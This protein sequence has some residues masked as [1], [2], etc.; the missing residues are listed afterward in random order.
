MAPSIWRRLLMQALDCAVLRALMKLGM[1]IAANRPMMATTIMISTNVKPDL[2]DVL[3]FITLPFVCCGV[4]RAPGGLFII[5]FLFTD[6]PVPTAAKILSEW[7][8]GINP[9]LT[10][11]L[12]PFHYGQDGLSQTK[13][14]CMVLGQGFGGIWLSS[15]RFV[16]KSSPKKR[17]QTAKYAEY[18]EKW[19]TSAYFA[20]SAVLSPFYFGDVFESSTFCANLSGVAVLRRGFGFPLPAL[21]LRSRSPVV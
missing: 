12:R 20:Y 15:V 18:A 4:N 10:R 14:G 1:A 8:Y 13:N 16:P 17:I 3:F 11:F 19:N 2:R 6:C 5:A 7:G 9:L 21:R